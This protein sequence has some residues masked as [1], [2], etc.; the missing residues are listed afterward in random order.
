MK[1]DEIF[2]LTGRVALITGASSR[3]IGYGAAKRLAEA[4]AK[5]FLVARREEKLIEKVEEIRKAGGTADYAVADVSVEEDCKNAVNKCLTIFGQLD[6]MVLSSGISGKH[7]RDISEKFDTENWNNVLNTN[8]NGIMYMV[9]YGYKAC[10]REHHGSII[11]IS[12]M[13]ALKVSGALPYTAAKGALLRMTP[14]LAKDLGPMGIRVNSV[15]PGL[16]DTDMTHPEGVD[17]MKEF[18]EQT[19]KKEP[20]KRCATIEDCAN[21][22]LYL[23]SDASYCVTGQLI[24]V[25][26]GESL[27]E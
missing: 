17:A 23:A 4:G 27:I 26:G 16:I 25:D 5:V 22:I 1:I 9:K 2:D 10:A 18:H 11:T 13:A 21:T 15:A 20:L 14:Y 19:A 7:A 8:L 6:I 3:G 12:S 24:A